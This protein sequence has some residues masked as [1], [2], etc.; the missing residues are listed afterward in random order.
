M[1]NRRASP[2]SQKGITMLAHPPCGT[3]KGS[4]GIMVHLWYICV[5]T[6]AGHTQQARA[7][8]SCHGQTLRDGTKMKDAT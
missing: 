2:K 7:C 4:D 8:M 5:S 6:P 3:V 1:F